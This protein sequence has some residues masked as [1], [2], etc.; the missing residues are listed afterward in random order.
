MQELESLSE[1]STSLYGNNNKKWVYTCRYNIIFKCF[2]KS[3]QYTG[4]IISLHVHHEKAIEIQINVYK[5]FTE[6]C[7][8]IQLGACVSHLN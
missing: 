2:Y 5:S 4:N 8:Y 1:K 3:V 7:F 6:F